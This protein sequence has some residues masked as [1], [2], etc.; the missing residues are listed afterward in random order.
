M[1]LFQ[2]VNMMESK[3]GG[4]KNENLAKR[5]HLSHLASEFLLNVIVFCFV[6]FLNNVNHSPNKNV[7]VLLLTQLFISFCGISNNL[8]LNA[9]A[10]RKDYP[11]LPK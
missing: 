5:K 3:E 4:V 7:L 10:V 1:L 11:V 8:Q 9:G 2:S 6:F